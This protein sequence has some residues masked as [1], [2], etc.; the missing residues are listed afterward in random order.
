MK[1]AAKLYLSKLPAMAAQR[2][3]SFAEKTYTVRIIIIFQ[4]RYF[5]IKIKAF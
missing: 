1:I 2:S 4:L 5:G 3:I